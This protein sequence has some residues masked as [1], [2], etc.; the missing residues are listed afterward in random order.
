MVGHWRRRCRVPGPRPVVPGAG[1]RTAPAAAQGRFAQPRPLGARPPAARAAPRSGQMGT[2]PAALTRGHSVCFSSLAA[3]LTDLLRRESLP[4]LERA[5]RHRYLAPKLLIV[6]E[7]GYL[8]CDS[9]SADLLY[10]IVSRRHETR[11]V[12]ITTICPSSSG[13]P[14]SPAPPASPPSSTASSSIATSS[15]STPT[16]GV[17]SLS[18]PRPK[19]PRDGHALDGQRSGIMGNTVDRLHG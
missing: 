12:V 17:R 10:N 13:A 11:S 3:L 8:P 16:P 19:G 14:Y 15:I 7:L 4:A 5:L 2:P 6:D 1:G 9:R 18:R